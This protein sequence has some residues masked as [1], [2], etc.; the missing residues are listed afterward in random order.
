MTKTDKEVAAKL[1]RIALLEK[2]LEMQDGLP[3]LYGQKFYKWQ[4]EFFESTNKNNFLVAANQ[5]GKSAVNIRKCIHWATAVE[6][7]PKLWASKPTQ[8]WYLYPSSQTATAEFWTK[9]E[10]EF[11]PRGKYKDHPVYGWEAYFQKGELK[12]IR[13][14]SGVML[15]FKTY[16]QDAQNLQAGTCYAIFGDEELPEELF[17]ELSMRRAAT[18]GYYH[19]VFTATL[20]QETWRRTME[21]KGEKELFPDAF[22]LNVR[23]WD[24][25]TFEDGS[26]SHWTPDR[27]KRLERACRS[28]AEKQRRIYGR[29]V[30][31]E[32]LKYPA[33]DRSL[34]VTPV[35]DVPRDWLVYA[36]VDVGGGHGGH[37]AAIAFIAV[38]PDFSEG[39]VFKGWRGDGIVTTA[40]D[41]AL[42][43]VEMKANL[44]VVAADY[45][46]AAK[47][48]GT[49]AARMGL[50]FNKAQKS[51]D[52]GEQIINVLF[53]N[54]MLTIAD[55]PELLPLVTELSTLGIDTPKNKAKDDFVDALR[56]AAVRVP[57]NFAAADEKNAA[58]AFGPL[59]AR[60]SD[61]ERERRGLSLEN[62]EES[63]LWGAE[64][65][66]EA[67]NELYEI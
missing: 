15:Y 43:F 67:L 22:K 61:E 50:T 13:F 33:F 10:P 23:M 66:L 47:D 17:D 25:L 48:F 2:R 32:G 27:I 57:W 6:L 46:F 31:D 9:W 54:R 4:R 11:L 62:D 51:H 20:G 53:K 7:W 52:I 45:D 42:K 30:K 1:E 64:T 29:F 41:V 40:S 8:F 18:D 58:S 34:N 14:N 21:E 59:P 65:E 3:H 36:G 44:P 26:P 49:I 19:N 35:R 38:S 60:M 12:H 56:Y 37:P 39:V 55:T 63:S 5:C 28:E 16:T 24:C